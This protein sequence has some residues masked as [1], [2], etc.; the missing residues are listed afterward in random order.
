MCWRLG[1]GSSRM[2]LVS[3]FAGSSCSSDITRRYA[4][5]ICWMSKS[6]LSHWIALKSRNQSFLKPLAPYLEPIN[7]WEEWIVLVFI[8]LI[9]A[10]IKNFTFNLTDT[11]S[12][13]PCGRR[14]SSHWAWSLEWRQPTG[15]T[16]DGNCASQH[17]GLSHSFSKMIVSRSEA[18][19]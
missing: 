19:P 15:S 16:A 10:I 13:S 18:R 4:I 2:M 7:T 5:M 9:I 3:S 6:C 17:P 8:S 11:R 12:V 14:T 1:L